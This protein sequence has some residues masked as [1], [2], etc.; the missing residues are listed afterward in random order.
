MNEEDEEDVLPD[1]LDSDV[2][3]VSAVTVAR[4]DVDTVVTEHGVAELAH[5]GPAE[6]ARALI[7]VAA[8]QHRDTLIRCLDEGAAA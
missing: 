8:P 7:A 3:R 4:S 6:R 5:L 1:G 2:P